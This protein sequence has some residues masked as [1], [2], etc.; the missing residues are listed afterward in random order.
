MTVT[1][2]DL[3]PNDVMAFILHNFTEFNRFRGA[4]RKS[5]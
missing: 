5:G 3:E 4:L 2:N 1:L